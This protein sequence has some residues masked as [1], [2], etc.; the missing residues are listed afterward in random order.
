[1]L[2]VLRAV[3]RH[4]DKFNGFNDLTASFP[5][6]LQRQAKVV[7]AADIIDP[8]GIN[9]QRVVDVLDDLEASA[10]MGRSKVR[11]VIAKA[12]KLMD[13]KLSIIVDTQT[14]KTGGRPGPIGNQGKQG[15]PGYQGIQGAEG[16]RGP[17]GPQGNNGPQGHEGP[18]G[19]RGTT[20]KIG[21]EV[22]GPAR[23]VLKMICHLLGEP[24]ATFCGRFATDMASRNQRRR[25][26][27]QLI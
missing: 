11:N 23:R 9:P 25:Q 10:T 24:Q 1:M 2:L 8:E 12:K 7:L 5:R 18:R 26:C 19:F 17:T 4:H 15:Y 6:V 27:C 22:G 13:K 16:D 14:L 3:H 20:G 21:I